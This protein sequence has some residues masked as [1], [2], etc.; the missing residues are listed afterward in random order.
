VGK[1]LRLSAVR[2]VRPESAVEILAEFILQLK[3]SAKR[4]KIFEQ[5]VT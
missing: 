4:E 3:I 1:S 5:V 2:A